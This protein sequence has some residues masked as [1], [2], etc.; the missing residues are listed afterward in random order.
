MH[1]FK[2]TMGDLN[3]GKKKKKKACYVVEHC[4][5]K[6]FGRDRKLI[7]WNF[8]DELKEEQVENCVVNTVEHW[9]E[10]LIKSVSCRDK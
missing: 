8:G 9:I 4:I 2:Y 1:S 10:E 5:H 6:I 3:T 7:G